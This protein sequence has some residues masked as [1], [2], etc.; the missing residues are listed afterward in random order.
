MITKKKHKII[1]ADKSKFIF[2]IILVSTIF[3]ITIVAF[4]AAGS[5]RGRNETDFMEVHI[6]SGD[7]LWDIAV[8]YNPGRKDIRKLVYD[9]M[10]TNNINNGIV[11]E[12]QIIKVPLY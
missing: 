3:I 11:F 5:V 6:V 12:G 2:F 1:I 7:T 4:L 8:T 10:K 9:I